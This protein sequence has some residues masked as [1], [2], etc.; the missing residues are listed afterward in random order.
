MLSAELNEIG[1]WRA[2]ECPFRIDYDPALLNEIRRLAVDAFCSLPR[3]GAEIGG[4]LFGTHDG[5]VVRIRDFH[6]LRCEYAFGPSFVL[7]ER[8]HAHLAELLAAARKNHRLAHLEPVGW[9][10]THTRSE[11]FLSDKDLEI[12][13]RYFPAAWQIALVL[14][15]AALEPTRAGFFFRDK[16]GSISSAASCGEFVLKVSRPRARRPEEKAAPPPP[17]EPVLEPRAEAQE[18]TVGTTPA[19]PPPFEGFSPIPV[20]RGIPGAVIVVVL[21]LAAVVAAIAGW[22]LGQEYNR[23]RLEIKNL[24]TINKSQAGRLLVLEQ[25]LQEQRDQQR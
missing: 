7:S 1:S 6:E 18:K 8:D 19:V 16:E 11:I 15:P 20:Q 21:V 2:G 9:Y 25:E 22:E 17:P 3:G 12:Y 10:H 4:I 14:R 13:Q 5:E 23:L 24:R